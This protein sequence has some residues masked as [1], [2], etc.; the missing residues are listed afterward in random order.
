VNIFSLAAFFAL[1]LLTFLVAPLI[2]FTTRDEREEAG[3]RL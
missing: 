1:A 2:T 3:V